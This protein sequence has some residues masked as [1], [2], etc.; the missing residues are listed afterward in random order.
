MNTLIYNTLAKRVLVYHPGTPLQHYC[1]SARTKRDT[2]VFGS[3][4]LLRSSVL[5]FSNR[6]MMAGGTS[7]CDAWRQPTIL[8]YSQ[9]IM[10]S[11]E[12]MQ[13]QRSDG[14]QTNSKASNWSP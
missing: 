1:V 7:S 2:S 6:I 10:I 13:S 14:S 4:I 8:T 9:F 12:A 3:F 5:T 11:M